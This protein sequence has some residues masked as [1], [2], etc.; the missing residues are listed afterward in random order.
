MTRDKC[1]KLRR[2]VPSEFL[3]LFSVL[4]GTKFVDGGIS[5]FG[6]A[7]SSIATCHLPSG[8]TL[9]ESETR[10]LQPVVNY[11]K[12]HGDTFPSIESPNIGDLLLATGWETLGSVILPTPLSTR[13]MRQVPTLQLPSFLFVP[14][15][16]LPL[17]TPE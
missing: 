1:A 10:A 3:E 6:E 8:T 5:Q 13:G 9:M 7:V 17:P 14:M 16:S 11:S 2:G 15:A 4:W 12:T